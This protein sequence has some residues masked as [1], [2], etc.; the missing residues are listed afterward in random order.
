MCQRVGKLLAINW[1][2]LMVFL[3]PGEAESIWQMLRTF[4]VMNKLQ[5]AMS[6]SN[7][8]GS[9]RMGG[10]EDKVSISLGFQRR[11]LAQTLGTKSSHSRTTRALTE[12]KD[13]SHVEDNL[14]E[15]LKQS[16]F[17]PHNALFRVLCWA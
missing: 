16:S 15:S 14:E 9:L 2:G 7:G 10:V 3:D 1:E 5:Q 6:N 13:W 11:G 12:Q 8:G 17:S 4:S